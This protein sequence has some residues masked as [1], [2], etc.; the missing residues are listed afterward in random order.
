MAETEGNPLLVDRRRTPVPGASCAGIDCPALPRVHKN[1][2]VVALCAAVSGFCFGYDIGIIDQVLAMHSFQAWSGTTS[3]DADAPQIKGWIV[4]TFLF[5]C[6]GGSLCVS[7]LADA[8]GRKKSMLLGALCFC[9]GGVGQSCS[10]SVGSL[11]GT[12][13]LSG[14]SIGILSMVAPLYISET[15]PADVRGSLIAVQ[16]L[17]ITFGVLVASCVN[18][19]I[20]AFGGDG[21]TQWR[22]AL[23]MQV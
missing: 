12:R 8:I 17:L 3:A 2:I 20:F 1:M 21:D 9:A 19:A 14:F 22:S 13:V 4:S 15:S 16:Q 5:G 18:A 7:Y 6:I 10:A 11:Y 23:A